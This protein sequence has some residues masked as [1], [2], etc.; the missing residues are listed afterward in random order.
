MVE[1]P[2]HYVLPA[3]E[4]YWWNTQRNELTLVSVPAT[5]I[6]VSGAAVAQRTPTLAVSLS[7]RQW[8]LIAGG[9]ALA[10]AVALVQTR[11]GDTAQPRK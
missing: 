4:Y 6:D 8:L 5:H 2:G 7:P 1:Q 9:V 3:R 10:I 11:A